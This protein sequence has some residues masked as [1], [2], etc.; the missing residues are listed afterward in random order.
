MLVELAEANTDD[1]LV[2]AEVLV[3]SMRQQVEN[4]QPSKERS[5]GRVRGNVSSH[6]FTCQ[7]MP[8][9]HTVNRRCPQFGAS[10]D[11]SELLFH[12]TASW[13]KTQ[14]SHWPTCTA[15]DYQ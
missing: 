3:D 12:P 6:P 9:G 2:F 13:V 15:S 10:C 7:L 8:L 4:R 14:S 11:R 5:Q 1:T